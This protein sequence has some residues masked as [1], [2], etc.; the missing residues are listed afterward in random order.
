MINLQHL[1][2]HMTATEIEHLQI[3]HQELD[4]L[5]KDHSHT[6]PRVKEYIAEAVAPYDPAEVLSA[7][8][9]VK[10]VTTLLISE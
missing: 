2:G 1:E 10:A 4:N 3:F 7:L 9:L 6:H 8:Q 5:I